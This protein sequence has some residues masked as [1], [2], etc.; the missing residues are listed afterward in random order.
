MSELISLSEW[1]TSTRRRGGVPA[2]IEREHQASLRCTMLDVSRQGACVSAPAIALPNIFVLRVAD[3]TRH[4]CDVQW[5]KGYTVGVSFVYI[6]QLLARTATA[7][8]KLKRSCAR[9][10]GNRGWIAVEIA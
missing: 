7:S 1:R 4:I 5:R 10:L 3:G 9:A 2:R 8:A 6:D